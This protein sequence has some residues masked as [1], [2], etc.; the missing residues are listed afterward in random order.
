MRSTGTILIA[1]NLA[2]VTFE[3]VDATGE[4]FYVEEGVGWNPN[5][6][7]TTTNGQG[8]FTEVTPGKYQINFGGTGQECTLR[9]AWPGGD[10][11]SIRLPVQE[12]FVT[13]ASMTCASF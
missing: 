5:L 6:T 1:T 4:L 9:Q 7:E 11:N 10:E 2:G 13:R 3:L 8:G 12:G